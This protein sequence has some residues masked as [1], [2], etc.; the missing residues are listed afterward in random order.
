M[1]LVVH[2]TSQFKFSGEERVN[3]NV[4]DVF[5]DEAELDTLLAGILR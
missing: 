5:V 4:V 3:P 1:I 2:D